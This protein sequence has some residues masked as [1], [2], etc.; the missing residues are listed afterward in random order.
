[1][2]LF[3]GRSLLLAFLIPGGLGFSFS[4]LI[5]VIAGIM[6]VYTVLIIIGRPYED[7]FENISLILYEIT[8]SYSIGL[9][10]LYQF[11]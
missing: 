3:L 7:T 6:G 5:Y 1:M 2:P 4:I 10:F 9:V 11:S 8:S